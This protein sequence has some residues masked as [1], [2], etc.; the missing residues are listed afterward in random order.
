M[1]GGEQCRLG[2]E[3]ICLPAVPSSAGATAPLAAEPAPTPKA[4][5]GLKIGKND[6]LCLV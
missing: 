6:D 4:D 1:R 5:F 3:D 2:T